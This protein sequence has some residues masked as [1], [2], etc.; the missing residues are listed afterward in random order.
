MSKRRLIFMILSLIWM[1]VIFCFSSRDADESEKDSYKVGLTVGKI[2]IPDFEEKSE[3][4]QLE[5]AQ[6]IDHSVRKAAHATEYAILG[7]LLVGVF[8]PMGKLGLLLPFILSALYAVTD[9]IHQ[10]FV[11]GRDGNATDVMI[12]SSGALIGVLIL[13]IIIFLKKKITKKP[14]DISS[15]L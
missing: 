8:Y 10:V 7:M 3:V 13:F 12:D 5:F 11:P 2:V 15:E 4:E 6:K 1:V 9:E 14:Q